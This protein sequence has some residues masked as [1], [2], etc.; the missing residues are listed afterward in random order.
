MDLQKIDACVGRVEFPGGA[1]LWISGS[2]CRAFLRTEYGDRSR[3]GHWEGL[4]VT[5]YRT[6]ISRYRLELPGL[7][8][9]ARRGASDAVSLQLWELRG[10][11]M[12]R[13]R[14]PQWQPALDGGVLAGDRPWV[15]E[16]V[17]AIAVSSA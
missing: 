3:S 6:V 10:G 16:L 4:P 9:P 13:W 7:S 5:V 8:I 12:W 15:M 1:H 11:E 14:F 2:T 17:D